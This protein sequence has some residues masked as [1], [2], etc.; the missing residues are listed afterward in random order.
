MYSFL[1]WRFSSMNCMYC[2]S[3]EAVQ[4]LRLILGR[5]PDTSLKSFPP[6]Y[7]QS[8]I[9]ICFEIYI[10]SNSRNLLQLLEFSYCKR[11]KS[12]A[13]N[14][15]ESY[16]N[17]FGFCSDS[18]AIRLYGE[19]AQVDQAQVPPTGVPSSTQPH[20]LVY[21]IILICIYDTAGLNE[22]CSLWDTV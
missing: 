4:V 5:N 1:L 20:S 12:K 13:R 14:F 7:S 11:E 8:P 17:E 2:T 18:F 21:S 9:Q 22:H 16:G 15:I 6:C 10:S 19:K 3:S